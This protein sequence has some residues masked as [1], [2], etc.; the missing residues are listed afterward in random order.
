MGKLFS[1]FSLLK[2]FYTKTVLPSYIF[3]V[4]FQNQDIKQLKDHHVV[5]VV[6]PQYKFKGKTTMYGAVP[7]TFSVLDNEDQGFVVKITYEDDHKGTVLQFLYELQKTII[8]IN[9]LYHPLNERN[10]GNIDIELK[11]KE[12]KSVILWRAMNAYFL[13]G[14]DVSLSYSSNDTL[15]LAL[16]F[17]ADVIKVL[18]Y[19]VDLIPLFDKQ[20]TKPLFDK[21]NTNISSLLQ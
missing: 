18:K 17:G 7:K 16:N 20:N 10:I 1:D 9:G 13:G 21:Q 2:F 8:D 14:E 12:G 15:K 4:R 11:N 19:K 5:D 3:S 6:I